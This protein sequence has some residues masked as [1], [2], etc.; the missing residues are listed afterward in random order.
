[1]QSACF[2]R[3]GATCTSCHRDPHL[4]DVDRNP[5]LAPRNNALCTQCHES[6]GAELTAHTRHL[7][8]SPG[9]SCVECHMPKT[10][11]SIKS[12]MR[13]HTIGVP[14]PEN[15]VAFGIPNACTECHKERKAAWAVSVLGKW[16]PG[17]RRAKL[18]ARAET[19]TAGRLGRPEVLD[20]LIALAADESQGPLVQANAL[21]YLGRYSDPRA[22]TALLAA[23]H[24]S[25]PAIRS[26]AVASLGRQFPT[27]KTGEVRTAILT[28]LDDPRRAVRMSAIV[29]LINLGGPPLD[30]AELPRFERVA[31][32]FAS[33]ART[34]EDDPVVQRDLG[35]IEL[36]RGRFDR[37]GDAL[38]ISVGLQPDLPSV[39]FLLALARLG[40]RR[41]DTARALLEQV[42]A[43]DPFY[44]AAQDRL[45]R[46]GP[47]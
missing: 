11:I 28:G 20:R 45:K 40:E 18:V 13:D 19:F 34:H 26:A 36:L 17:G 10:V 42:A 2:L 4:P 3:G 44:Q 43:S 31:A 14:A 22:L 21:G 37:A 47:R 27:D 6:I 23:A 15:T 30:A 25:H 41:L 16:R 38:E 5:Q 9:S 24:A 12:S 29:A 1:L 8:D 39:K 7:A 33:R 35:L 32:E 46:L